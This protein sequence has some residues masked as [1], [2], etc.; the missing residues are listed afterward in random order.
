MSHTN[1]FADL[2][3]EAD[4]VHSSRCFSQTPS[5]IL[6]GSPRTSSL[7]VLQLELSAE[8]RQGDFR[9]TNSI[10]NLARVAER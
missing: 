1:N 4:S 5:M 8:Y 2:A 10:V 9:N 7:A 3:R 6:F